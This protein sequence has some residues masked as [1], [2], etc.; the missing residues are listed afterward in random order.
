L[1]QYETWSLTLREEHRLKVFENRVLKRIFGPKRDEVMGDRRKLHNG[2]LHNLYSSPDI[3][4]QIKSRRMRW[5]GHVAQMG[6]GRNMY[7]FLVRNSKAKR[8]L[9]RPR[10]RWED[11]IKW[12]LGRLVGGV[13]SGFIWHRIRIVGGLSLMR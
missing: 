7:R 12:T 2:E 8:P 13:W 3:I 9:E 6:E 5:A 11:G 1:Y 4:R 10:H